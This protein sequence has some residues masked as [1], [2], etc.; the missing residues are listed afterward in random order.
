MSDTIWKIPEV[1]PT[2]GVDVEKSSIVRSV[3][4]VTGSLPS[5]RIPETVELVC[6][7]SLTSPQPELMIDAELVVEFAAELVM[8]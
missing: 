8:L 2:E 7:E 4:P 5:W 3:V 6:E 1:V